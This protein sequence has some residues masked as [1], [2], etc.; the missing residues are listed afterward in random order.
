MS[1]TADLRWIFMHSS[2]NKLLRKM[3]QKLIRNF[4]LFVIYF[5]NVTRSHLDNHVIKMTSV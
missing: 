3:E 2:E 5:T 1:I 4:D